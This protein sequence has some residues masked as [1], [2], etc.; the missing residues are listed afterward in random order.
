M[1]LDD[2]PMPMA[3]M[4]SRPAIAD[5]VRELRIGIAA[6]TGYEG[7]DVGPLAAFLGRLH[8]LEDF[9]L[10][11][12]AGPG[13]VDRV[14]ETNTVFNQLLVAL[15]H[16]GQPRLVKLRLSGFSG[17]YPAVV[18]AE[19]MSA[20]GII[21]QQSSRLAVLSLCRLRLNGTTLG[22]PLAAFQPHV[23]N[24]W[25]VMIDC[26]DEV[27]QEIGRFLST[28]T[29]YVSIIGTAWTTQRAFLAATTVAGPAERPDELVWFIGDVQES[30]GPST[31]FARDLQALMDVLPGLEV[32]CTVPPSASGVMWHAHAADSTS[33]TFDLYG[34]HTSRVADRL[35][36]MSYGRSLNHITVRA[37]ARDPKLE[38]ICD[39]RGIAIDYEMCVKP[40]RMP[41]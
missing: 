20:L 40:V 5:Y 24:F 34:S 7:L 38:A 17:A 13:T 12:R 28:R 1:H 39:R 21:L 29:H 30:G 11:V 33:R 15:G 10:E 36:D 2:P 19:A 6:R 41:S 31:K 16:G 4:L 8:H 14:A 23:V 32:S 18:G 26:R 22:M 3:V 37:E 9:S 27:A 35:S 25:G